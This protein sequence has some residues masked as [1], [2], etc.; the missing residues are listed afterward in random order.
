MSSAASLIMALLAVPCAGCGAAANQ[1]EYASCLREPKSWGEGMTRTGYV[2]AFKLENDSSGIGLP[3]SGDPFRATITR[4]DCKDSLHITGPGVNFEGGPWLPL[5]DEAFVASYKTNRLA[6]AYYAAEHEAY[7]W[8]DGARKGPYHDISV[9]PRFSDNGEHVAYLVHEL[10]GS[11]TLHADGKAITNHPPV[12][13]WPFLYVLDDGRLAAPTYDRYQTRQILVGDYRSPPLDELCNNWAFQPGPAG[14]WG[15]AAKKKGKWVTVIDGAELDVEGIPSR[16]DIH[17][18]KDGR[19]AGYVVQPVSGEPASKRG[20]VLDGVYHPELERAS[21]LVFQGDFAVAT[22]EERRPS[23]GVSFHVLHLVGQPTPKVAPTRDDYEPPPAPSSP[24]W[25]QIQIGD[26]LG[27][28]LDHLDWQSLSMD[29]DG[30][31]RYRGL[32]ASGPVELVDNVVQP[33][34]AKAAIAE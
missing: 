6:F 32:R 12:S 34:K 15:F 10:D 24:A 33:P 14:H 31:I 3:A 22:V 7:V 27:P 26:S 9:S 23:D 4:H 11:F 2:S 19:H 20:V 21:E 16:C 18:S 1:S 8:L 13:T 28:R 17:F 5:W 30:R 29:P 25:V